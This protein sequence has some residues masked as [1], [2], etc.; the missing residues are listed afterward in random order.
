[1]SIGGT[2]KRALMQGFTVLEVLVAIAILGTALAA[3][4]GL[5]QSSIRAALG[6][7]RAQQRIALDRGALA[8]LRS[9]NPVLEPEGRA[10]LSLGAE[11]QW[12][13]E[14]LGAARRITSAIGAEGRFSLQRFR[15]LVTITAP[16]LPARSWSVELL[17]WQPVQPFLPAG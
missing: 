12:R 9:I 17:G 15:V 14:P 7:E 4:L 2:P 13:S 10:E 8:L 16:D 6:V 3:L 11:M 5:Q 1:M